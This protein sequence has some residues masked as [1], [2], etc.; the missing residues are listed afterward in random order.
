M[1]MEAKSF[2]RILESISAPIKPL[3]IRCL[4]G[5]LF[6]TYSSELSNISGLTTECSR[7]ELELVPLLC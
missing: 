1:Y 2:L 7:S 5:L 3:A 4:M 6:S